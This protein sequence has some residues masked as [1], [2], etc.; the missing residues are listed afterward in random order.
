MSPRKKIKLTFVAEFI[1]ICTLVFF[2]ILF[3]DNLVLWNSILIL[4]FFAGVLISCCGR[5]LNYLQLYLVFLFVFNL[6]QPFLVLFDLYEY[7]INNNIMQS[8]GIDFYISEN[9]LIK[10]YIALS[11][12]IVGALIGWSIACMKFPD[13]TIFYNNYKINIIFENCFYLVWIIYFLNCFFIYN[14]SQ[15]LGYIE[16]VHMGV[17]KNFLESILTFFSLFYV[18]FFCNYVFLSRDEKSYINRSLFS[19]VPF[20]ILSFAGS[21]GNFVVW[22]FVI[23]MFYQYRFNK[24]KIHHFILLLLAVFSFSSY[25]WLHRFGSTDS[26]VNFFSDLVE[27]AKASLISSGSSIGVIG[28]TFSLLDD[29]K[30]KVPFIFGYLDSVVSFV[31]NYTDEGI[32][33]KSYL[34]QHLIYLL[35]PD[36]FYNG[37]T[38]GT[39][40]VA[41]VVE[42]FGHA[43]YPLIFIV[44]AF[45]FI[46]SGFALSRVN[47]NT[48]FTYFAFSYIAN[49]LLSPRDSVFRILNKEFIF[50]SGVIITYL[51]TKKLIAH[52]KRENI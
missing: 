7:P 45:V 16:S 35:N 3:S 19:L 21:R 17:S 28:Y 5:F 13:R 49:L 11:F 37:S 51:L 39:A 43:L 22:F 18:Y 27:T 31:P 9:D 6:S 4:T 10:T 26:S 40:M 1:I 33:D 8:D 2:T 47:K 50:V 48:F 52:S 23:L 41:E 12:S 44:Y 15:T 30:N 20:L 32:K 36:K 46:L 38:L 25:I 42:L 24:L 14:A 34:S 29:F